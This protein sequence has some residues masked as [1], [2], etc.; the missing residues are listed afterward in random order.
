MEPESEDLQLRLKQETL[1]KEIIEKNYDRS[2]FIL[3]CLTKKEN[4]DDLANWSLLELNDV[5]V[6]FIN[7]QKKEA[8]NN[9]NSDFTNA[10]TF[11]N[12]IQVDIERLKICV[13]HIYIHS[14]IIPQ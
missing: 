12:D 11:D 14:L 1:K 3:F 9:S 4:G 7:E 6:E 5:I 10:N 13:S 8:Q 2:K